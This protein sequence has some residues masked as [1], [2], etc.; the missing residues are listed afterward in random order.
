MLT[1]FFP[2]STNDLVNHS[3]FETVCSSSLRIFVKDRAW[4]L[5]RLLLKTLLPANQLL[6][7]L[8]SFTVWK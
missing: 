2:R 3:I 5:L 1:G 7:Q 6:D 4:K 8:P